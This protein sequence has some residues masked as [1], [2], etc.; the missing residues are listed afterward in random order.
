MSWTFFSINDC[1]PGSP[2]R[3]KSLRK[4]IDADQRRAFVLGSS[5]AQYERGK[6]AAHLDDQPWLK[7]ADHAVSNQGIHAMKW[8]L[9][10][11]L[12]PAVA[13]LESCRIRPGILEN[14]FAADRVASRHSCQSLRVR[15]VGSTAFQATIECREWV[16][17]NAPASREN[18]VVPRFWK[19]FVK[20]SLCRQ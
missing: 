20:F 12:V 9:P 5:L 17:R 1:N 16:D 3:R 11:K 19:Q 7:M 14:G 15:S 13:R 8:P 4:R 2:S 18:R 10:V 6:T